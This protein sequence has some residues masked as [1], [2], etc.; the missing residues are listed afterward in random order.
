VIFFPFDY[1]VS[2]ICRNRKFCGLRLCRQLNE[3]RPGPVHIIFPF[4]CLYRPFI[5]PIRLKTRLYRFGKQI[6]TKKAVFFEFF[7][8]QR[9]AECKKEE[10][11]EEEPDKLFKQIV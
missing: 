2:D 4:F 5:G 7:L 1:G 8:T 3:A 11:N 6:S 9:C 10:E